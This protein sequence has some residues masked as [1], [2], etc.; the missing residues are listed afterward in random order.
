MVEQAAGNGAGADPGGTFRNPLNP[1]PDPFLTYYEGNYYLSTSQGDVLRIWKAPS[2]GAQAAAEP[3]TVWQDGD[4]SRNQQ[5]WAPSFHLIGGHWYFYYT[6][7]DG[8]DETHRLYVLKSAGTD[9]LGPYEFAAQLGAPDT[10]AIDPELLRLGD[11]LYLLWSGPSN[12]LQIAPMS[13]PVTVSGPAVELPSAGGCDDIREAPAVIQRNGTIYLV[14]STCDTGTPDYQLWMHSLPPGADP[15]LPGSWIQHPAALF[16]RNDEA[17]VFGPGANGFFTSPDGAEDWIIYHGK[18][19]AEY[20]YDRRTTRAQ[21]FTW[22][23]DGTPNF[24]A[25]VALGTD[26]ALPSGDPGGTTRAPDAAARQRV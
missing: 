13:D 8:T 11:R 25:P 9:P 12:L 16:T 14:Y 3:V 26:L 6:A 10:W 5:M 23:P 21:K 4:A 17:G 7:S 1:G 22:N 19:T 24:G 18:D 2:L 20:T 15:L